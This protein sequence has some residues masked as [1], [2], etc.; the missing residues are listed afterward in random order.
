MPRSYAAR[1]S[2]AIT[3]V[4]LEI[5]N[6]AAGLKAMVFVDKTISSCEISNLRQRFLSREQPRYVVLKE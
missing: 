5:N 1:L 4:A 2:V 3:P 6:F